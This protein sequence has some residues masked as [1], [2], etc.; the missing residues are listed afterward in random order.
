MRIMASYLEIKTEFEN[1]HSISPDDTKLMFYHILPMN[2]MTIW[3]H[4]HVSN[5]LD[6]EE[7]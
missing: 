2:F 1:N 5:M 7:C 3:I 4:K 6:V